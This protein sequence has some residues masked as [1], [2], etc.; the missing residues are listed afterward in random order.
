MKQIGCA[1]VKYRYN[2]YGDILL[3]IIY[4]KESINDFITYLRDTEIEWMKNIN[5]A[6]ATKSGI[7]WLKLRTNNEFLG[8]LLNSALCIGFQVH[9]AER[10][11]LMLYRT[12]GI[13][14]DVPAYGTHYIRVECI[15]EN[16]KGELLLVKEL[17]SSDEKWKFVTGNVNLGE[18]IIDAAVREVKEE[19]NINAMPVRLLGCD[20]NIKKRFERDEIIIVFLLK[21]SDTEISIQK[22][23]IKEARWASAKE[24]MEIGNPNVGKWLG[25][26]D[27]NN[28]SDEC[29]NIIKSKKSLSLSCNGQSSK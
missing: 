7:F 12:R 4:W 10:N 15:V 11:Y 5:E 27:S 24:A 20:N 22:T 23:E 25:L 13:F 1:R 9:F 29:E 16:D 14:D 19:T 8:N 18:Y 26:L 21:T 3:D 2:R 28:Y 6:T 17:F